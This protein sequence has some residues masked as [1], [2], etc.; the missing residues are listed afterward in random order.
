[1]AHDV[2]NDIKDA[3]F[4]C[5]TC[6]ARVSHVRDFTRTMA[7]HGGQCQVSA[8]F[9]HSSDS[10]CLLLRKYARGGETAEHFNAKYDCAHVSRFEMVCTRDGC[11]NVIHQYGIDPK[12]NHLVERKLGDARYVYDVVFVDAETQSPQFVVE[13]KETHAVE[14]DKREHMKTLPCPY[15]EVRAWLFVCLD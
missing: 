2:T 6:K 5:I 14:Y 9:R 7:A 12:W 11:D 1:M 8:H 15:V 13:V 3:G 4:E 10:E